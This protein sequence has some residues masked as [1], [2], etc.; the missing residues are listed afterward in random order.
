MVPRCIDN[1]NKLMHWSSAGP[2]D[3]GAGREHTKTSG[4]KESS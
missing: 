1:I 3:P 2:P 4:V